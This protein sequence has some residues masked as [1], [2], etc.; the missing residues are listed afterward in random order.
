MYLMKK[1]IAFS[2]LFLFVFGLT[3][4]LMVGQAQADAPAC[5]QCFYDDD[6]YCSMI[7]E[8]GC[9]PRFPYAYIEYGACQP[10]GNFNWSCDIL[11]GCCLD[12]D[13][14]LHLKIPEPL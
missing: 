7:L 8:D 3:I 6:I 1:V 13:H 4:G 14:V 9:P 2:A 10:G 12:D 11:R 5:A